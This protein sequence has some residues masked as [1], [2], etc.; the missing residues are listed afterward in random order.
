[1]PAI[2]QALRSAL[3][4]AVD[5]KCQRGVYQID[6][7]VQLG[8]LYDE[9]T[10]SDVKF[11]EEEDGEDKQTRVIAILSRGWVK[12]PCDGSDEILAQICKTR[13]VVATVTSNEPAIPAGDFAAT[14]KGSEEPLIDLAPIGSEYEQAVGDVAA[15]P[16]EMEITVNSVDASK[17]PE[18]L[19]GHVGTEGGLYVGDIR[20]ALYGA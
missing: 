1:L 14:S 10:M 4:L 2:Q 8:D 11:S 9:S 17:E 12:I 13:V 16:N 5:M 20:L 7:R 18:V 19:A 6:N 15:V 3:I